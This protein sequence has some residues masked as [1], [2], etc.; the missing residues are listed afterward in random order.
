MSLDP[1]RLLGV[2]IHP[3]QQ[4]EL[5]AAL[6]TTAQGTQPGLFANVNI[7]A[8]NLACQDAEFRAILNAAHLV[9]VDGAGVSLGARLAG[10]RVGARLTPA[11]WIDRWL[12]QCAQ[13]QWPVF[14]LG[15]TDTVGA[16]FEA[17]LRQRH[18]HCPFAGRHHGFFPKTGPESTA[19]VARINASGA[20]VLLVGMSMPIQEKWLWAHRAELQPPVQLAVGGLARIY[21]GHIRRG[22][23]WMTDYGL[24]W[25]FRLAMQPRYT[26]RRY[27]LGNPLFILRVLAQRLGWPTRCTRA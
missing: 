17:R 11:D 9:F 23:R 27:L 24:E 1:V 5:L 8:M 18:P 13:Q 12:E 21:T 16:D 10:V 4:S 7:H 3:V 20:R 25:L 6:A 15:D 2:N 19:V 26:W 14:W 22:P